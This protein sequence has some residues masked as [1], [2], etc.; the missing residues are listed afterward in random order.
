MI[1][2]IYFLIFFLYLILTFNLWSSIKLY[3][4]FSPIMFLLIIFSF[5]NNEIKPIYN[6]V[7]F[8]IILLPFYKYSTFNNGVGILDSFPSI[9]KKENKYNI[10]WN[11]EKNKLSS[12]KNIYFEIEDPRERSFISILHSSIYDKNSLNNCSVYKKDKKFNLKVL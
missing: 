12:C 4:M 2:L 5:K 3:F 11:V 1:F 9:I 7:I 8:L 10:N 6:L